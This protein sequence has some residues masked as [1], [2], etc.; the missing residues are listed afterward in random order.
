MRGYNQ[1]E[2]IAKEISEKLYI[3]INNKILFRIKNPK[4]QVKT[5]TRSERLKNQHNTFKVA[6]GVLNSNIILV[7]DVTTT[8]ATIK[9][10]RD[11]LI[12]NGAKKVMAIT[13]AH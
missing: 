7:D 5:S 8:G 12:K 4:R 3:P 6:E 10:A 13:I 2:L 9:E 1:A 11:I